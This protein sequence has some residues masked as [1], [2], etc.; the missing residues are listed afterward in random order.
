M[1]MNIGHEVGVPSGFTL[2]QLCKR[3]FNAII[4]CYY[5]SFNA[6]ILCYYRGFN[7]VIFCYDLLNIYC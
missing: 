3:V 7:A 2:I 6:V 5:R 1:D 4:L